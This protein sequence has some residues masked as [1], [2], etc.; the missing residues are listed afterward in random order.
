MYSVINN[1]HGI[2][3]DICTIITANVFVVNSTA[4]KKQRIF[5]KLHKQLKYRQKVDTII[6][7]VKVNHRQT[8]KWGEI[9]S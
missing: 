4:Y 1:F 5:F 2:V 3:N 8:E 6:I 9:Q 7:V